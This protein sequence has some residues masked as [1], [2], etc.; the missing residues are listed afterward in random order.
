M[1]GSASEHRCS[2][3]IVDDDPE[4]QEM[5][6]VALA[7]EEYAVAV[8]SSGRDAIDYLRSHGATCAIVLDLMMPQMNGAE[9][10]EIQ[11]R[12]RSLA[13]IPTIVMSAAVDADER[14]RDLR[15]SALLIKP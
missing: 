13:W 12:D 6:R 10:R 1:S 5:L 3:L 11:L 7:S 2:I 8:S 4:V 14:V 15:P 9:F